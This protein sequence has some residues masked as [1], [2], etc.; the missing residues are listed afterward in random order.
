MT[1][2]ERKLMEADLCG[3]IPYGVKVH[4]YGGSDS[5]LA[6]VDWWDEVA[7]KDGTTTLYP[8]EDVKP[9]LRPMS[10]MTDE[11]RDAFRNLGGVMSHNVNND[12]WALCAFS[13]E[14]YDWLNKYHF[15]YRNLIPKGLALVG[16]KEMYGL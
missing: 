1:D 13:P 2:E 9:Y 14:A 7:L 12:T 4:V 11:E 10:D 15:D 16:T 6:S 3:R 8:L 5:I